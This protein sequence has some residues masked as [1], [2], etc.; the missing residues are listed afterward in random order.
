L[1]NTLLVDTLEDDF[2]L[3][4]RLDADAF[5]HLDGDRVRITEGEVQ[6]LAL[7]RRTISDAD[8]FELALVALADTDRHIRQVR[9]SR[10]RL[11]AIAGVVLELEVLV[12]LDDLDATRQRH[13]QRALGTLQGDRGVGDGRGHALGQFDR[14]FR[15]T[16][17]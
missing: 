12:L 6:S 11:H 17:H 2:G 9:A 5:W 3:A 8:Q 10:T 16:S 15:Y 7:Y 14:L 13:A 4:R 1:A